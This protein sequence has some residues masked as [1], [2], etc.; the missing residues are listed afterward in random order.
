V[1][2]LHPAQWTDLRVDRQNI[3]GTD[4][5]SSLRLRRRGGALPSNPLAAARGFATGGGGGGEARARVVP[6]RS[7]PEPRCRV[8]PPAG[9][10]PQSRPPMSPGGALAT[11][12]PANT[13]GPGAGGRHRQ[14]SGG[15]SPASQS[16]RIS[17]GRRRRRRRSISDDM[18]LPGRGRAA[19]ACGTPRRGVG[20]RKEPSQGHPRRRRGLGSRS[21]QR[22][23]AALGGSGVPSA[24]CR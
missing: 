10:R 17:W 23:G 2:R 5:G 13:A 15:G 21:G 14:R 4:H 22:G 7:S 18:E 8:G 9:A 1:K 12:T 19:V 11:D 24:A 16:Q 3:V 20:P 6:L